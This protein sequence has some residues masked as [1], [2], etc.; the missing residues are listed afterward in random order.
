[1]TWQ[2]EVSNLKSVLIKDPIEAFVS[3]EKIDKEWQSL[4]YLE[5]PDFEQALEEYGYFEKV[6]LENG[7]KINKL[8]SAN[9]LDSLYARD[10]SIST[11]GGMI[12]C[13][14][15]KPER[16]HEPRVQA[17]FYQNH[18]IKI[19]GFIEPPGTLEGGDVAWIDESTIAVARGYRTNDEGI[20]QLRELVKD[21]VDEV[22]VFH[23]PHYRGPSDVFHL[24]SVFSPIDHDLAVVYSPLMPVSF[25]ELLINRG[26]K[27]IE[28]P[29]E[30]FDSLGCNVL[31]IKPRLAIMCQGNPVTKK[32]LQNAGVEVLEYCGKEIS[33]KGCG[34][35][36]CLTRPL[37]RA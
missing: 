5:K 12:I 16:N 6:L 22:I 1:M 26:I 4:N 32:R 29:E 11:N 10:A 24:M 25:R 8:K 34:G 9:T 15:G 31:A 17:E 30:E 35:P 36:T 3:Q 28:V 21:V 19:K 13:N 2:S 23:S 33:L 20:R 14:M 37:E 7:V 18:G 27:L